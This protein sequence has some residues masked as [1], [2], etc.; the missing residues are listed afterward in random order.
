[1][2]LNAHSKQEDKGVS[3]PGSNNKKRDLF[4]CT[5]T[6]ADRTIRWMI[7]WGRIKINLKKAVLLLSSVPMWSFMFLVLTV[8]GRATVD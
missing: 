2:V 6:G 5:P 7:G 1:M 3:K 8:T 4:K